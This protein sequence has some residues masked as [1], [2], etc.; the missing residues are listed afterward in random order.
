MTTES[1]NTKADTKSKS[2]PDDGSGR[3][4]NF[5]RI[6]IEERVSFQFLKPETK[7]V[8]VE[9]SDDLIQVN[10]ADFDSI[11]LWSE[12]E[13]VTVPDFADISEAERWLRDSIG[14]GNIRIGDGSE[15]RIVR[16]SRDSIVPKVEK[17]VSF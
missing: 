3:T 11:Q 16:I 10:T 13:H 14:N 17:K 6:A 1:Q 12:I 8:A 15:F 9:G 2:K 4:R 5:G 7:I